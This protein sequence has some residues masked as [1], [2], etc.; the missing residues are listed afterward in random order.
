MEGDHYQNVLREKPGHTNHW[1]TLELEGMES[2]KAAIGAQI[3]VRLRPK[4]PWIPST[5]PLALA[6]A[7]VAIPYDKRLAW[8]NKIPPNYSSFQKSNEL[9]TISVCA[10]EFECKQRGSCWR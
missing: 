10:Q 7:S 4:E 2:N 5:E 3:R 6:G 8:V 9:G 1:I